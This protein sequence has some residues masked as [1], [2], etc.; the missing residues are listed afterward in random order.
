MPTKSLQHK[1][2]R[3]N[4]TR[5]SRARSSTVSSVASAG[6]VDQSNEEDEDGCFEPN[7]PLHAKMYAIAEK[8][9]VHG[10]KELAKH[11]FEMD[12]RQSWEHPDFADAIREVY[13]NTVDSDR[14]LRAIVIQTFREHPQVAVRKDV[15]AAIKDTPAL[16]FELYKV[17][18]GMP[19]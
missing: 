8:Y 7:L 1:I 5:R 10:L 6:E 11:K 3:S 4:S 13:E 19:I 12:C 18:N 16:A 14:G 2:T 17:S 9:E 15:A